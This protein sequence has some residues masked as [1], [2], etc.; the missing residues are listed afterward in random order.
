MHPV[1]VPAYALDASWTASA[2]GKSGGNDVKSG[3]EIVE[4]AMRWLIFELRM[5][6]DTTSTRSCR[7]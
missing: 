2:N 1:G 3:G 5:D 4:S 7:C 6:V